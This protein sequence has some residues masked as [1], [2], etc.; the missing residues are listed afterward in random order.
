MYVNEFRSAVGEK[1]RVQ[2]V[3]VLG[4]SQEPG[5]NDITGGTQVEGKLGQ[6]PCP[7]STTFAAKLRSAECP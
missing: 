6:F 3:L 5:D 7:S 1:L 4:N 2:L